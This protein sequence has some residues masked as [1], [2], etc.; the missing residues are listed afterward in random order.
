M[1]G[2]FISELSRML[3]LQQENGEDTFLLLYL[4]TRMYQKQ[5]KVNW[6]TD[7]MEAGAW[8]FW[9]WKQFWNADHSQE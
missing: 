9:R 7:Q 3:M 2:G 5:F 6:N 4:L 8:I 1:K